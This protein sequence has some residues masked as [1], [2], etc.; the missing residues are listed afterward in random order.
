MKCLAKLQ[1]TR[2]SKYSDKRHAHKEK[3]VFNTNKKSGA[4]KIHKFCGLPLF[5]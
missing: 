4:Q 3:S 2:K 1:V 5:P